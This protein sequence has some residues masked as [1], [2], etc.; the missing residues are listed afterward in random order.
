MGIFARYDAVI[1]SLL[2]CLEMLGARE[3]CNSAVQ[4]EMRRA[5]AIKNGMTFYSRPIS[6]R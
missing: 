5:S 4:W 1:V 3:G 2:Y 6:S